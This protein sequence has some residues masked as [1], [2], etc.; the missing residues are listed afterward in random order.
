MNAL[1]GYDSMNLLLDTMTRGAG[2]RNEIAAE[3][4]K[5]RQ[6]KG[7]HTKFTLGDSRVNTFLTLLQFSRRTIRK[8]GE[9][10]L[11]EPLPAP[12]QLP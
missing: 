7:W 3:L 5:V 4:L 12:P 9:F 8:I 2:R 1:I 10:D 11:S 6:F